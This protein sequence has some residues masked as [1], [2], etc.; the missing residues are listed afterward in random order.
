M[1]SSRIKTPSIPLPVEETTKFHGLWGDSRFSFKK[2]IRAPKTK[3]KKAPN[4]IRGVAD[5]DVGWGQTHPPG[6]VPGHCPVQARLRMYCVWHNTKYRSTPNGQHPQCWNKTGTSEHF[7]Q[8]QSPVCTHSPTKLLW[9]NVGWSCECITISKIVP[10]PTTQHIMPYTNL[11]QRPEICIFLGKWKGRHDPTSNQTP[12][13][14]A[15]G[16]HDLCDDRRRISLSIEN[17]RL[18]AWSTCIRPKETNS[19]REWVN[20]WSLEKRPKPNSEG[21][22]MLKDHILKSTLVDLR[23]TR[24]WGQ[25]RS[26]AVISRMVK[27]PDNCSLY[28]FETI[29]KLPHPTGGSD[30]MG[31]FYTW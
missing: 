26:S 4:L 20:F 16:I 13:S 2:H 21:I 24:G 31:C 30:Q 6:N 15:R 10:A 22:T 5:L 25:Q 8:V 18:S 9:K 12:W 11:T 17:T 27:R 28:R 29:S 14:Q 3:C 7:A 19:L 1:I 23:L